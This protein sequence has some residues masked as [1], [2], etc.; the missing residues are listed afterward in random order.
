MVIIYGV[1][2]IG[3]GQKTILKIKTLVFAY[4]KSIIQVTNIE[5]KAYTLDT[6]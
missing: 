1:E 2:A 5:L 3:L 6:K 4:K